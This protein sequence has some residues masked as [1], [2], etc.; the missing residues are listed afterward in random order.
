MLD[1]SSYQRCARNNLLLEGWVVH[2][3]WRICRLVLAQEGLEMGDAPVEL[4]RE[5]VAR[6]YADWPGAER[7]GF[8]LVL[9][10]PGTWTLLGEAPDGKREPLAQLEWEDKGFQKLFFMHI[11]KAGGSS[12]NAYFSRQFAPDEARQ[13]LESDPAWSSDPRSLEKRYFLSGHV[14]S[15]AI[16]RHLKLEGFRR[17]TVL[18]E[19]LEQ[20]ISHLAWI[21]RLAAPGEEERYAAH[22]PYVRAFADKLEMTDFSDPRALNALVDGLT[23]EERGLVDNCQCRYLTDTVPDWVQ[24]GHVSAAVERLGWFHHVGFVDRLDDF[25]AAVARAMGWPLPVK[26]GR[27]NV[28][29]EFFGL[30]SPSDAQIAALAPLTRFDELVLAAARSRFPQ[31]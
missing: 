13:H 19:P 20:L 2:P 25:L 22:P 28:T 23:R 11:A 10:G 8:R 21:R 4:R 31:A 3:K 30:A 17:V 24:A 12:V 5:A 18:R 16:D 6:A 7:P 29:R 27:E 26:R 15:V 1:R 14:N 9:P